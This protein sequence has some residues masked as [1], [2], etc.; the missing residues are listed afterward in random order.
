MRYFYFFLF[1]MVA[2]RIHAQPTYSSHVN[3][4]IGT[5]GFGHTFP[6]ATTPFGMVQLSPDTRIDGSWEGC[7]G[8]HYSDTLLYGFSHTHLSGT[9]CSDYGDILLMPTYSGSHDRTQYASAFSHQYERAK[10]GYY[11]VEIIERSVQVELTATPR[12][13]LH[14]YTFREGGKPAV[15]L[16]LTHR[17]K[18]LEGKIRQVD[19][20]TIEGMRRSEA[21]A[22]DQ[23]VFF[24]IQFSQPIQKIEQQGEEKALFHFTADPKK[25]LLVKVSLSTVDTE[26]A[27]RNMDTELPGWDF[28]ATVKQAQ[29]AWDAE[30]G[31]IHIKSSRPD[32]YAIFYT[33]LYH[34]M[35]HPNVLNDVDGRYRGRDGQVHEAK[36]FQYYSVF[37]LWDTFRGAHPLYT[38]LDRRRTL[39]FIKT[40]LAQ[41]EQ[42]GRLP[43][44]ELWGNETDCMIG[45]HSV[46]VIADAVSKGIHDFDVQKAFEAM[47]KSATWPHL[48]LPEYMR[49]GFIAMDDEHEHVSKTL[50]YAYDDWCI[51]EMARW[52]K[53]PKAT[54]E[55]YQRRAQ[56][57]SQLFD[58][59]TGFMR[60]MKNGDWLEPFDPREVNN[61][62]TE[63]NSWQYSFFVPHDIWNW[64]QML[65]GTKALETKL[66]GLFSADSKTTGREQVDISGLVGQYA[67]GNEPS[68]HI[69][70]L[71]N[72]VHQPRKTQDLVRRLLTDFYKNTPDGLIGNEDCGQMSAWYVWSAMGFYPICPGKPEYAI[73]R[74]HFEEVEIRLENGK[75]FRILTENPD[76]PYIVK[77]ELNGAT[78]MA[79]VMQHDALVAGGEWRV[80]MGT[81][82]S[83]FGAPSEA[84]PIT[85]M[86]TAPFVPHVPTISLKIAKDKRQALAE[87]EGYTPQTS[88][89]YTTDGSQ[90]TAASPRYTR[91]LRLDSA[92][93]VRAIAIHTSGAAS[94]VQEAHFTPKPN[95]W[96]I[97]IE[98]T[99][100]RQYTAGGDDGVI[101]GVRGSDNWRKGD[102]QG[103]QGQDVVWT[104]DLKEI[105][106][107]NALFIGFLQDT[108]SWILM[109]TMVKVEGSEK[110]KTFV[111]L[112]AM[113]NKLPT[114]DM[115]V[116]IKNWEIPLKQIPCRY[117]RIRIKHYGKL[118]DWH[119]GAGEDAF[120]FVDEVGF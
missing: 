94:P 78:Y 77:T 72:C 21:W 96:T 103:Y 57:Y 24:R 115:N 102:W 91:P 109:P 48:G 93:T 61:N 38:L 100:N 4:F 40:F 3:P 7:S 51:A 44:W 43:V 106:T 39:D 87:I 20:R 50:E 30:L 98:G 18:L 104:I 84:C 99:Y 37:S 1:L 119:P 88:L 69:A 54:I 63:G 73:G 19:D 26:G 17:D 71:Y 52:T 68:H 22:R 64:M 62:F 97:Q 36:G 42:A 92:C 86:E 113:E 15:V 29:R 45:Y 32:D 13:G 107:E 83:Y 23:L 116:Q 118:P 66:D 5:A 16:D 120:F 108:R 41:Y 53:Q 49:R 89:Y 76:Q 117:L 79:S 9:G 82:A 27:K 90:P 80:T 65:G 34:T 67:H 70:Y 35:I 85:K 55:R 81:E 58:P 47:E 2:M 75:K 25:P 11:S 46:S 95:R 6:G 8:Y 10:A 101:N 56:S 33:A 14:R 105:R 114:S 31:K 59:K 60:P 112:G 12:V 111:E 28:D 110:G 74:P